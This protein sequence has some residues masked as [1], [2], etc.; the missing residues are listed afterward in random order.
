M[1]PRFVAGVE[2]EV[3]H[4]KKEVPRNVVIN[5]VVQTI[6][7]SHE[8]N[9]NTVYSEYSEQVFATTGIFTLTVAKS[10]PGEGTV[11]PEV[12][13]HT[14]DEETTVNIQATPADGSQFD[15]W[16]GDVAD[17][18]SDSTIVT[19]DGDKTVTAHF[20]KIDQEA[21]VATMINAPATHTQQHL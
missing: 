8:S 15:H 3:E 21:P 12:G 5:G 17:P 9:Q 14:Y 18:K 7:D 10:G 13:S 4:K 6:T 1:R 2:T 20:I 16:E 19:M 11:N